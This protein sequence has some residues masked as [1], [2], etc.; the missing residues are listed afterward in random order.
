[1]AKFTPTS[2]RDLPHAR[3]T[4]EIPAPGRRYIAAHNKKMPVR[5]RYGMLTYF[6][7]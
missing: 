3:L 4:H 5:R 7:L 6:M 1:M 2:K